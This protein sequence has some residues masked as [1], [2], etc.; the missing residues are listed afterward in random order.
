MYPPGI[1]VPDIPQ[2]NSWPSGIIVIQT[3]FFLLTTPYT[4]AP[5][6]PAS[7]YPAAISGATDSCG[8]VADL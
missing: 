5:V 1:P 8:I 6:L 3:P 4:K 2:Q 7:L